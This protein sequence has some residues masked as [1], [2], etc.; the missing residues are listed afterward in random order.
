MINR[1]IFLIMAICFVNL[2]AYGFDT[3]SRFAP[4]LTNKNREIVQN[5]HSVPIEKNIDTKE[6]AIIDKNIY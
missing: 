4:S 6:Y 1:N 2:M 5:Y 3:S